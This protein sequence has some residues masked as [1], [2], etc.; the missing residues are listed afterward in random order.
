[1]DQESPQPVSGFED[2]MLYNF[3][4]S[5]DGKRMAYVTG[6]ETREIVLL[7]K[8]HPTIVS[9]VQQCSISRESREG[10]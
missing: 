7:K 6:T 8:L 5:F 4:W 10:V 3:V 2:V 9:R 1:L